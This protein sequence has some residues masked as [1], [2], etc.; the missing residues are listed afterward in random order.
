VLHRVTTRVQ[1][2]AE[3]GR[4][5]LCLM[6]RQGASSSTRRFATTCR[7]LRTANPAPARGGEESF[8]A[9][10]R[11]DLQDPSGLFAGILEGIAIGSAA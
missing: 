8:E 2:P 3:A 6:T 7:Q 1:D 9:G 11:D 5:K 10:W 4:S